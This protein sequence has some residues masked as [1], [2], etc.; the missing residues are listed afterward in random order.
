MTLGCGNGVFVFGDLQI[1]TVNINIR[2][3]ISPVV[4]ER[5]PGRYH[6]VRSIHND[7]CGWNVPLLVTFRHISLTVYF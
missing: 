7:P 6:R 5:V 3:K 4:V 2:M 1:M